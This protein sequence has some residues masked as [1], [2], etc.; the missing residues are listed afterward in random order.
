MQ[1]CAL[2]DQDATKNTGLWWYPSSTIINWK[3][4]QHSAVL[5]KRA[6]LAT[7][8]VTRRFFFVGSCLATYG[9]VVF[10]FCNGVP[11]DRGGSEGR[12]LY[13]VL[14]ARL[15]L[16]DVS[17]SMFFVSGNRRCPIQRR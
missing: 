12:V 15:D 16:L 13:S 7:V 3:R 2:G 1:K 14:L 11:T 8:A 17:G 5:F 6:K 10:H 9:T 4:L